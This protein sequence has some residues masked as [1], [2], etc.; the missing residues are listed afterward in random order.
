MVLLAK[1]GMI[2]LF[3][4]V[5]RWFGLGGRGAVKYCDGL[6]FETSQLFTISK[7]TRVDARSYFTHPKARS[8][9]LSNKH[10][11]NEK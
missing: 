11:Y 3:G 1:V 8:K 9:V 5:W 10:P 6:C 7:V 2:F 4:W